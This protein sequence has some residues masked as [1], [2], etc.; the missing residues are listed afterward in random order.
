LLTGETDD[1]Q[2]FEA[3]EAFIKAI[4]RF[5]RKNDREPT[6]VEIRKPKVAYARALKHGARPV[7][8][9]ARTVKFRLSEIVRIEEEASAGV[10]A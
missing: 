10:G 2:K 3:H 9:N 4:K 6:M 7:R 8:F 5:A 1:K